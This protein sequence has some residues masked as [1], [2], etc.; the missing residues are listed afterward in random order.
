MSK[1]FTRVPWPA[2]HKVRHK[3]NQ[4]I[5]WVIFDKGGDYVRVAVSKDIRYR[6]IDKVDWEACLIEAPPVPVRWYELAYSILIML[7]LILAVSS[8]VVKTFRG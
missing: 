3:V 1:E 4:Q 6:S 5:G 2:G 8:I 7:L